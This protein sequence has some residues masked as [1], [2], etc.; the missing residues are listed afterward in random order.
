MVFAVFAVMRRVCPIPAPVFMYTK[1]PTSALGVSTDDVTIERVVADVIALLDDTTALIPFPF[2]KFQY[3]A[4][5]SASGSV[6]SV[7]LGISVHAPV[8]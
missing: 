4:Y 3:F 2:T 1:F 7:P 8:V 6:V 5:V